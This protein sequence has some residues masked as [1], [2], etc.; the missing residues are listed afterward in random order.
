MSDIVYFK[1]DGADVDVT[2]SSVELGSTTL[3]A[4]ETTELGATT[5]AALETIS[6]SSTTLS[7]LE[8]T[9]VSGTVSLSS[10]TLTALENITVGG[11]VSLSTA[12]LAA[13]ET[14]SISGLVGLKADNS[15]AVTAANPLSVAIGPIGDSG[16][17]ITHST[18]TDSPLALVSTASGQPLA[19]HGVVEYLGLLVK[20]GSGGATTLSVKWT[21]GTAS[22]SVLARSKVTVADGDNAH[23]NFPPGTYGTNNA[24]L[25]MDSTATSGVTAFVH[26]HQIRKQT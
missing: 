10:G 9:T 20:N 22:K 6:L 13:L 14:I 26:Y 2:I 11:T 24:H 25:S 23:I 1:Q 15:S 8:N 18:V 7:A 3:T 5:L 19:G 16:G 4:L 17:S 21:D 12:S